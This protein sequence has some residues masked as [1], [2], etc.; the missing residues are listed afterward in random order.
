MEPT[1]ILW[2]DTETTGLDPRKHDIIQLAAMV[3][4][5]GVI[6]DK[7]V[8]KCQPFEP[9][10]ADPKALEVNGL[11]LEALAKEMHPDQMHGEFCEF[12]AEF[13]NRFDTHDKFYPAGFNVK[14]DMDFL[15]NFFIACDDSFFG[16]W[17]NGYV[18]DAYPLYAA[19]KARGIIDLPNLKLQ[20]ICKAAGVE[21][22]AHDAMS[23]IEAT[24]EIY[25]KV[26]MFPSFPYGNKPATGSVMEKIQLEK[27]KEAT[28]NVRTTNESSE[29]RGNE[30]SE[31]RGDK[32]P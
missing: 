8:W 25:E 6:K 10:A 16:S 9:E 2:I 5:D 31:S 26:I 3:E 11:T 19:L 7:K 32:A 18:L 15:L 29:S 13:I 24:R 30:S 4:I 21:I 20:T 23:D 28:K 22:K 17:F 12:M 27:I 14:F 1:K